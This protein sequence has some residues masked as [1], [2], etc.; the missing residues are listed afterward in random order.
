MR[1]E[2]KSL[3]SLQTPDETLTEKEQ[4]QNTKRC[5]LKIGDHIEKCLDDYNNNPEDLD[6]WRNNL[7]SFVAKFTEFGA[8][9]LHKLYRTACRKRDAVRDEQ[10]REIQKLKESYSNSLHEMGKLLP[11]DRLE[12]EEARKR[13]LGINT[14]AA[15]KIPKLDRIRIPHKKKESNENDQHNYGGGPE[16]FGE[17]PGNHGDAPYND[18]YSRDSHRRGEY[19]HR[20]ENWRGRG[21]YHHGDHRGGYNHDHQRGRYRKPYRKFEGDEQYRPHNTTDE[22]AGGKIQTYREWKESQN[23]QNIPYDEKPHNETSHTHGKAHHKDRHL[24]YRDDKNLHKNG[25]NNLSDPRDKRGFD[26]NKHDHDASQGYDSSHTPGGLKSP[27]SLSSHPPSSE[28]WSRKR[29]LSNNSDGSGTQS[30]QIMRDP[31]HSPNSN[32][33]WASVGAGTG[34]T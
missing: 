34:N 8:A 1:A 14:S 11:P 5:L 6:T 3:Q 7:W 15:K 24:P 23:K 18:D 13:A 32:Q 21:G 9:K 2:R 29:T 22:N 19:H 33:S 30:K 12:M 28:T 27:E 20:N 4:V 16:N 26:K 17:M 25:S 10:K 31:D